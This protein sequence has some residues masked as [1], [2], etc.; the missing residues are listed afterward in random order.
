MIKN[1]RVKSVLCEYLDA[2]AAYNCENDRQHI[3]LLF[4]TQDSL[5]RTD[6]LALSCDDAR[7]TTVGLLKSLAEHGDETAEEIVNKYY[8]DGDSQN[9]VVT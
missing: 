4:F 5:K 1:N 7:K 8:S 2:N 6:P 9:G 3:I